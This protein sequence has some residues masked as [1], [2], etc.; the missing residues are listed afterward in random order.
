MPRKLAWDRDETVVEQAEQDMV[1]QDDRSVAPSLD[2]GRQ[3]IGLFRPFGFSDADEIKRRAR[4]R[5]R[6]KPEAYNVHD[7][8]YKTGFIQK[9][10]KHAYFENVT[11]AVIVVNAIWI[12]I[13]ADENPAETLLDAKWPFVFA[14]VSFFSYFLLELIIRF[15]AFERKCNCFKDGWFVF[16]TSLVTLYM[17]DPFIITLAVAASGGAKI[18]LPTSVLRLFRLAR[19]SRLVRMLR[20]LPELM[21]MIK[22]MVTAAATVSYTLG[23][24]LIFTYVFAIAM[25]QLSIDTQFREKYFDGVALS[26][27]S[28]II[29]G[30][31]LDSLADFCDDIRAESTPCLIAVTIF[32]VVASMTVMNMLIGVLCEV[33]AAVAEDEKETMITEKVYDKLGNIVKAIDNDG[34]GSI[35]F[36]QLEKIV[37]D[38]EAL[39]VLSSLNVDP[40]DLIDVVEDLLSEHG[41]KVKFDDFME[42]VLN[43]RG[44]LT[45]KLK[46]IYFVNKRFNQKFEETKSTMEVLHKK[47]DILRQS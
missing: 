1:A 11:L 29:Y 32:V 9:V 43:L 31:F 34:D 23:L 30:T 22:G 38:R 8:Y 35:S 26:M 18:D 17:F 21:I 28:L 14:D 20:S 7:C 41:K 6:Q 36:R 37:D 27:Y 10:A 13:D 15:L 33:I 19:L 42:V 4:E 46:D 5:A 40:T 24:L 12:A 16:D 39:D 2:S 44:G 47:L 25:T 45:A 3:E